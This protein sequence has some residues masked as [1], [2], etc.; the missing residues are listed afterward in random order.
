MSTDRYRQRL[1]RAA[2]DWH[3]DS[4]RRARKD[5]VNGRAEKRSARDADRRETRTAYLDT[6]SNKSRS[7][8]GSSGGSG[9]DG[10]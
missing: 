7:G 8:A 5:R 9:V 3:E 2:Y 4:G 10:T 6:V 1:A